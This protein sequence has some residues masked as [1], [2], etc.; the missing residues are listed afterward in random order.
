[1]DK[2]MEFVDALMK[3]QKEF[4]ESWVQSQKQFMESWIDTTRKIQESFLSLGGS[5]EGTTKETVNLYRSWLTT[6]ANSTKVY[7]E[8]AGK[9]QETWK[10][11]VEKQMDMSREMVKNLTALFQKAA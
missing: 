10:N 6:M 5:Q 4:M 11:T 2:I 7:T 3:S 8:E 9:I 1:M